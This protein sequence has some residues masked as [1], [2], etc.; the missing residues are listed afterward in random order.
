MHPSSS[1]GPSGGPAEIWN[2]TTGLSFSRKCV[3]VTDSV[4]GR[5]WA[6][7]L[8]VANNGYFMTDASQGY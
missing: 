2:F 3:A 7:Q 6:P 4:S 8:P 5:C 1:P